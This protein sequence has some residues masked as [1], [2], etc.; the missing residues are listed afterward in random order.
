M[1]L[2]IPTYRILMDDPE[3]PEL[4]PVEHTVVVRNV[5]QLRAELEGPKYGLRKLSDTPLNMTALWLWHAMVR[6]GTYAAGWQEFK[7]AM[8][9]WEP[10][11]DPDG[12]I[13]TEDPTPEDRGTD[14]P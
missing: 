13:P 5:D 6:A 9:A 4:P 14:S 8:V 1:P 11:K 7:A 10:V 2:H 12:E 3:R